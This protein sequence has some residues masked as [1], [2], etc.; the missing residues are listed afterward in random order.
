MKLKDVRK[1]FKYWNIYNTY[2]PRNLYIAYLKIETKYKHKNLR[3]VF[4]GCR[5]SNPG[6]R[7]IK[8]N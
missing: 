4:S 5:A 2:E 8:I 1:V 3:N 6:N 7:I